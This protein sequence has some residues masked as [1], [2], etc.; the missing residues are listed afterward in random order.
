MFETSCGRTNSTLVLNYDDLGGVLACGTTTDQTVAPFEPLSAF[1]GQNPQGVWTLRVRDAYK[2]D[3]GTLN[4]ASITICTQTFTLEAPDFQIN[5]FVLY[6]N[7]NK[8]NFNIQFT[9]VSSNGVKVLVHDLLGRK[10]FEN[11]FESNSNFNEN[12]QLKNVQPGL[13]LLT[14]IDGDRKEVRKIIIE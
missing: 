3:L 2:A 13:Y 11:K 9:S 12:I 10:L 1:N 8:G 14:V 7:P 5:D 6:P 4:S